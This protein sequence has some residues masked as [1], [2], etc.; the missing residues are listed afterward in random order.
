MK[1][2]TRRS[3]SLV[4]QSGA[5]YSCSHLARFAHRRFALCAYESFQ[6]K[7]VS[8][9]TQ[10]ALKRVEIKKRIALW[11]NTRSAKPERRSAMKFW[12]NQSD[13]SYNIFI[14]FDQNPTHS[15]RDI[16]RKRG[17]DTQ[18]HTQSLSEIKFVGIYSLQ[19]VTITVI[20]HVKKKP[21]VHI[22]RLKQRVSITWGMV[23]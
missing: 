12:Y 19:T 6:T 16:G 10:K 15:N 18:T 22:M 21:Y 2:K 1:R 13:Q 3:L 20:M 5:A 8:Q 23:W 11:P 4:S 9:T 17:T 14:K 7:N